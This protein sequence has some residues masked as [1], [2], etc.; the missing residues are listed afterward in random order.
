MWPSV[1]ASPKG[2]GRLEGGASY[3]PAVNCGAWSQA[4]VA[5]HIIGLKLMG[6]FLL[7]LSFLFS[8]LPITPVSWVK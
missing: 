1:G 4:P 7:C 3:H 8:V 2:R 6:D 5:H